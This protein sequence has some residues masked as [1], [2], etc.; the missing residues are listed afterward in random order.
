M[1][2]NEEYGCSTEVKR[3]GQIFLEIPLRGRKN[4]LNVANAFAIAAAE[5]TRQ[6]EQ[7][8]K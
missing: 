6:K 3:C 2:G 5:M 4:S 7:I 1:V 8:Q